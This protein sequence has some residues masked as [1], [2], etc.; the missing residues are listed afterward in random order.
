MNFGGRDSAPLFMEARWAKP[1]LSGR[2]TGAGLPRD[3]I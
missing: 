2:V 3:R 1:G